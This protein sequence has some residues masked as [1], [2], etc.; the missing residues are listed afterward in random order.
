MHN[1]RFNEEINSCRNMM[2]KNQSKFGNYDEQI[3]KSEEQIDNYEKII[4]TFEKNRSNG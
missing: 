4:N 2:Q 3:N 1:E